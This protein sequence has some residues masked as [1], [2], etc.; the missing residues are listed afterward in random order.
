MSTVLKRLF[1]QPHGAIA[2][3]AYV[4]CLNYGL[5]KRKH[6]PA[7]NGVSPGDAPG[8]QLGALEKRERERRSQCG[9]EEVL[10]KGVRRA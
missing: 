2:V 8:V 5:M 3:K 7:R 1:S 6:H 10:R 9:R 4:D